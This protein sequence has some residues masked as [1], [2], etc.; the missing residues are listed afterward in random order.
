MKQI[1]LW[2]RRNLVLIV[3]GCL[4]LGQVLIW[5]E[6]ATIRAN[7]GIGTCGSRT[8]GPCYVVVIPNAR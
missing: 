7:T 3:F 1:V 2:L 6:L 4:L 5:R 8:E